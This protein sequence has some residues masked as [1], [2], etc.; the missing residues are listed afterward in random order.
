M[1]QSVYNICNVFVT[2]IKRC[3]VSIIADVSCSL[4]QDK[5]LVYMLNKIGAN[6]ETSIF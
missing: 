3:V 2:C 5:S 1:P 4:M 6:T